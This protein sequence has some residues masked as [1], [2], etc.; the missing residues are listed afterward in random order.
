MKDPA[1]LFYT[2][3][4]HSGTIDMSCEEVGAYLRLLMYQHQHEKIPNDKERLMR[5]TG[6]FTEDKFDLVWEIVGAKFQI[7]GNHLVNHRLNQEI[8]KRSEFRPKKLASATFAGLIS[9]GDLTEKQVI[10][11]KKLFDINEFVEFPIDE[12]KDKVREWFNH[13]VN[14]MVDHT[15]NNIVNANANGNVN[16]N[17]NKG[18]VG[19]KPLKEKTEKEIEFDRFN[20]WIDENAPYI[21]RIKNQ[22]TVEEYC[23]LSDKYNGSQ[24][25]EILT[26]IANYKDA[27][28][29]YVS[30][31]LT[32]QKW[33]K[34]QYE[35][36]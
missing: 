36:G 17:V 23:R 26:A 12:I 1:F 16:V 27:P 13:K 18:G 20:K 11:I 31:N 19:E 9:K 22:I 10:E 32:F 7:D 29:K 30:V 24:M 33:A 28:K 5:I 2:K 8:I 25:R 3:D 6:I 14:Q 15:V 4:F 35:N 34:K 21:R